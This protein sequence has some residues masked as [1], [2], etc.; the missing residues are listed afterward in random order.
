MRE[1]DAK[2]KWEGALMAEQPSVL[3]LERL[4]LPEAGRRLDRI[5]SHPV[6]TSPEADFMKVRISRLRGDDEG[7]RKLIESCL[8]Q[9]PGHRRFAAAPSG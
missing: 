5:A 8:E 7:A 6:L 4:D 9:T 2:Q 1:A 3:L